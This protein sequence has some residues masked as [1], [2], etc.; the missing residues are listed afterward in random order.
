MPVGTCPAKPA[1][2][3]YP[4]HQSEDRQLF[5]MKPVKFM[6]IPCYK[7]R[8]HSME[9]RY[10]SVCAEAPIFLAL[11]AEPICK[12]PGTDRTDPV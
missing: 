5:N 2:L 11:L 12:W 9:N 4:M 1:D 6:P 8:S 7:P 3:L 10:N